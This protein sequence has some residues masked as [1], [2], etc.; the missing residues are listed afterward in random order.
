MKESR[1]ILV[2]YIADLNL[3]N[4]LLL[5]ISLFPKLTKGLGFHMPISTVFNVIYRVFV[6]ATL[7][8]I[9]YGL[10]RLRRWGYWLMFAYNLIFLIVSMI[11]IIL[12][13]GQSF[14]YPG[15]IVSMIGLSLILSAKRYFIN[16]K[17]PI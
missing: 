6:I 5:L 11:T 9:S 14:Q 3:L 16:M 13:G 17:Q 7:I 2:S 10:L 12:S 4:A 15:L 8:I 1:P